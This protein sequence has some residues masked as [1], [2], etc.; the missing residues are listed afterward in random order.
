M[1][2]HARIGVLPASLAI[3]LLCLAEACLA[4]QGVSHHRRLCLQGLVGAAVCGSSPFDAMAVISSKACASGKGDGCDDLAEGNE[5]IRSLQQKSAAKAEFYAKV[6]VGTIPTGLSHAYVPLP[7]KM[8]PRQLTFL[9]HI[10]RPALV[11]K[12]ETLTT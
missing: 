4:Y 5:L 10:L 12:H 1:S 11:R 7:S 2:Q 8:M 9:C 6:S 3:L